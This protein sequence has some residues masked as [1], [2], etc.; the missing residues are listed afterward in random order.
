MGV[1]LVEAKRRA[2]GH[3]P[4]ARVVRCGGRTTD[5]VQTGQIGIGVDRSEQMRVVGAGALGLALAG[6]PVVRGEQED[7]VVQLAELLER[8]AQPPELLVDVVDHRGVDGHVPREQP[9]LLRRQV[10]P[11]DDVVTVLGVGERQ[12]G[13]GRQDA[14]LKHPLEALLAE[15][16]PAGGVAA[17]VLG[18]VLGLG[19]QRRVHG[20]VRHVEEER[21][22]G[23]G[24]LEALDH[25]DRL[26]GDVVGEVVARRVLVDL[27]RG[28]V[29]DEAVRV[30]QVGE[31]VQEPV[32]PLE[33]A[34]AGP[35]V[36]RPG[37]G[38]VGVL[39]QVPLADHQRRPACVAQDLGRRHA[40]VRQLH[41][42][43]REPRVGVCH[44]ADADRVRVAPGQ[45]RRPGR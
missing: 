33:P 37:V 20:A 43:A 30:V 18:D 6:G 7:R 19:V 34:L 3:R 35:G 31:A 11:A 10:V 2:G 5:L 45:Q 27:H 39:G 40:V 22:G 4:A 44:E 23:V 38:A 25:R 24:G 14:E 8:R 32:E 21:L 26:V 36:P 9:L 12:H 41:R 28:V 15:G 42:V 1:D 29:T 17:L 16:V 13:V